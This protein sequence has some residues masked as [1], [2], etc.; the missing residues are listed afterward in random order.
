MYARLHP[1]PTCLVLLFDRFC[2][3]Q[4]WGGTE[5]SG[6][7]KRVITK[8]EDAELESVF[9]FQPP[10]S[11]V[12][13]L[14]HLAKAKA[15]IDLTAGAGPWALA[16]INRNIPYFGVVLSDVHHRELTAH[17]VRQAM[18]KFSKNHVMASQTTSRRWRGPANKFSV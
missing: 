15:I 11:L 18:L 2:R 3:N 4:R 5:P 14:C 6:Q 13:E 16:A 12:E 17:L 10:R 9:F 8:K 7:K 1:S